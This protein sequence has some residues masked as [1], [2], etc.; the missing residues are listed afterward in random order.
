M[1]GMNTTEC[2]RHMVGQ[3]GM[4]ARKAS[5]A[6]GKSPTYLGTVIT[7]GV[8]VSAGNLAKIADTMGYELLLRKEGE[9]ITVDP[10]KGESDGKE[11]DR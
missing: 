2:I 4:S 10:P 6:L 5:Q 8:D 7:N 9:E 11:A 3:S 1:I